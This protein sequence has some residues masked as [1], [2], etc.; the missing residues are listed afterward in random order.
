MLRIADVRI[1]SHTIRNQPVRLEC[2]YDLEREALYSVKWYKD[3]KEFYRFLPGD[4]PPAQVFDQP[5]VKV[6]MFLKSVVVSGSSRNGVESNHSGE[7]YR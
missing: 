7:V 4:D 3:G 1:P 6:D 5:G 2:H